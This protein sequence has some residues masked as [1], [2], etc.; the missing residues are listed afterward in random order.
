MHSPVNWALLGLIIERP[1]YAFELATRFKRTYEGAIAISS[2]SHIYTALGT[3]R[4]RGLV[5]KLGEAPSRQRYRA[6][7]QGVAEHAEWVTG[8]VAEERRRQRV[9]MAQLGALAHDPEQALAAL[10][11]YEQACMSEMAAA[12][13]PGSD[14]GPGI[15]PLVARLAGEET[16]LSI[17]ARLRW[18][19]Y[20]RAQLSAMARERPG[21]C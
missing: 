12:P 15:V 5:E 2:P 8:Q 3:L 17:A 18:V 21:S 20:A 10:D 9:L 16:R 7:A 11:A 4:E 19:A 14:E 1:S 13:A 6:T